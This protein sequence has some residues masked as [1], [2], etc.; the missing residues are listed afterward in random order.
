M[1]VDAT[2]ALIELPD[3]EVVAGAAAAAAGDILLVAVV[4]LFVDSVEVLNSLDLNLEE[5]SWFEI[6][7]YFAAGVV[8][9]MVVVD[10]LH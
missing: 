8:H 10:D 7:L 1:E 3:V 5:H 9:M 6:D 2:V 4:S